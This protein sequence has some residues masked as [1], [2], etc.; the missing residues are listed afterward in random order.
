MDV[1]FAKRK[2]SPSNLQ[3]ADAANARGMTGRGDMHESGRGGLPKRVFRHFRL[4]SATTDLQGASPYA[5]LSQP[6]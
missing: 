1:R 3:P 5:L 6:G 2:I 4:G